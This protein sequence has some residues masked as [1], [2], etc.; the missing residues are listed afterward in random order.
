ML[1]DLTQRMV[2]FGLK[3][4]KRYIYF[5]MQFIQISKIKIVRVLYYSMLM[6]LF[7]LIYEQIV[8]MPNY[9]DNDLENKSR[10]F[11][12]FHSIT[13]PIHYHTPPSLIA[14]ISIIL[15]WFQNN[16]PKKLLTTITICHLI[17]IVLTAYLVVNINN[18]LFFN[19]AYLNNGSFSALAS[20]WSSI[21]I[22]RVLIIIIGIYNVHNYLYVKS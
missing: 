3:I 4:S 10:L 21:N 14:T 19:A 2:L 5:S 11:S 17:M 6:I 1:R 8:F 16:T 9:Y 20:C 18:K 7:G 15:L 13:N 12:L 22:I